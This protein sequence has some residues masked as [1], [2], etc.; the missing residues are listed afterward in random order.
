[1]NL[2][3][4]DATIEHLIPSLAVNITLKDTLL[5]L[6]SKV[7]FLTFK[8]MTSTEISSP[9]AIRNL[10]TLLCKKQTNGTSSL[11]VSTTILGSSAEKVYYLSKQGYS[12]LELYFPELGIKENEIS[13][14]KIP[15]NQIAHKSSVTD[16]YISL[17]SNPY[18]SFTWYDEKDS[19]VN[20]AEGNILCRNDARFVVNDQSFWLEQDM[21]TQTKQVIKQK[22]ANLADVIAREYKKS[23]LPNLLFTVNLNYNIPIIS[24]FKAVNSFK[25]LKKL[26]KNEKEV[27]DILELYNF[28][29]STIAFIK[30]EA[31]FDL[32]HF[33]D[34]LQSI[35][36]IKYNR[37]L[38]FINTNKISSIEELT[39]MLSKISAAKNLSLDDKDTLLEKYYTSRLSLI[40][41]T[42]IS[43][44]EINSL[45]YL[46]LHKGL[47]VYVESNNNLE[48]LF[49][50][51]LF[52]TKS[53]KE[54][55]LTSF[56]CSFF[57]K[58]CNPNV[59]LHKTVSYEVSAG[60]VNLYNTYELNLNTFSLFIHV[61]EICINIGDEVRIKNLFSRMNAKTTGVFICCLNTENEI[62]DFHNSYIPASFDYTKMISENSLSI[63]YTLRGTDNY[64]IVLDGKLTE[65]E[66]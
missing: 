33:I 29:L 45:H 63:Y 2:S 22:A 34:M 6:L 19:I 56:L 9:Y 1:M 30:S 59:A 64:Y 10:L 53:Y 48:Q 5:I 3:K 4:K 12:Y 49:H 17:V 36:S 46:M 8:Q 39:S 25:S 42:L 62:I 61:A 21:S 32:K 43:N 58:L 11:V 55:V 7:P 57:P 38:E 35:N 31:Q 60:A 18:A 52:N 50:Y 44:T 16:S 15:S 65:L 41:D 28:A 47:N 27:R 24:K 54:Q 13:F 40:R 14:S 23:E 20:D 51:E 26:Y 37:L 66:I